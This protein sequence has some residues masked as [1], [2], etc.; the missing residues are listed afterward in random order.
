M[1]DTDWI[2]RCDC[3]RPSHRMTSMSMPIRARIALMTMLVLAASLQAAD[4]PTFRK[5]TSLLHR[6]VPFFI[7][8]FLLLWYSFIPVMK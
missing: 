8:S 2:S 6:D 3:T 4:W 7:V 5:G 1:V